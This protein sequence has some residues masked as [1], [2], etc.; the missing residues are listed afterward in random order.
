MLR[1]CESTR[2]DVLD[3]EVVAERTRALDILA[4]IRNYPKLERADV[5]QYAIKNDRLLPQTETKG[6]HSHG[7]RTTEQRRKMDEEPEQ[8]AGT[9]GQ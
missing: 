2:T 9:H 5:R 6:C 4:S 1:N 3:V 7:R 8:K